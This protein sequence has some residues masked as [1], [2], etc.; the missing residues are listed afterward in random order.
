MSGWRDISVK[1]ILLLFA[2][3]ILLF[4]SSFV[5]NPHYTGKDLAETYNFPI[6]QSVYEGDS[7][8]GVGGEVIKVPLLGNINF[9]VHQIISLDISGML[10][11]LSTGTVPFDLTSVS[12]EHIDIY[13][14][15]TGFE[16]PGFLTLDGDKLTVKAPDNYIWGYNVP[17]KWLKKT[18]DGVDLISNNTVVE[19]VAA[20]NIKNQNWGNDFFNITTIQGW[21][22]SDADEG[23]I[24]VLEKGISNFSD[25]RSDVLANEVE[26]IFGKNV[27]D[28]VAAYP[29]GT[30]IV[31][32][33][34]N[35]TE[36]SG[37]VHSTTLGSHPEY[38]N[39]VREYN[40]RQFVEAWN[41]TIIPPHSYGNGKAYIDFGSAAD[42]N[43]PGG[44]ASHGVC[45]PARVLRDVAFDE[46]FSLP[47]G[48]VTG[49]NAVL[50]GYNPSE[51]I[52]VANNLDVP[53]KIVMWTEGEGT[54]MAIC[55]KIVKLN[56]A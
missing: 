6:G 40:A 3:S 39:A 10:L 26:E 27:S 12:K 52:K 50:F 44:G 43:A 23:D 34:G 24:F 19:H 31:L 45:P 54:G 36:E 56:P 42:S 14:I 22:N 25:G 51:D 2:V 16:G 4:A 8:L 29:V 32:Y 5:L 37:E 53:V 15:A 17:S 38:G 35:V 20:E 33:M 13:G 48:M 1:I 47:I 9:M 21:Y 49:E 30:P 28:Y 46:G 55:G 18:G 41:N 7:I 11:S